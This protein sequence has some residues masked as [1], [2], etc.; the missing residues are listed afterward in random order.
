M[1]SIV[2]YLVYDRQTDMQTKKVMVIYL[3]IILIF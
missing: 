3:F 2:A 1:V